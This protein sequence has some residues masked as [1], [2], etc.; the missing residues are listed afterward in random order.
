MWGQMQRDKIATTNS[1][2]C[3][4][5]L[6]IIIVV[7]SQIDS[8][9]N[10]PTQASFRQ[11]FDHIITSAIFYVPRGHVSPVVF[12]DP[13]SFCQFRPAAPRPAQ[14]PWDP[15][16]MAPRAMAPP[17]LLPLRAPPPSSGNPQ[18]ALSSRRDQMLCSE[19]IVLCN[20]ICASIYI[21]TYICVYDS[22]VTWI[23]KYEPWISVCI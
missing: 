12:P 1:A 14:W 8:N 20:F 21:Y 3:H 16:P 15:V 9:A 13:C 11:M 19:R 22:Y 5:I 10:L 7:I 18:K 17:P 23:C 4:V 6:H 2:K